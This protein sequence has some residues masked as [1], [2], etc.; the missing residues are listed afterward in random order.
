M[1]ITAKISPR[2]DYQRLDGTC[3]LRLRLFIG[4]DVKSYMIGQKILLSD[5]D[6]KGQKIRS[7]NPLAFQLN[8]YMDGQQNKAMQ[9]ILALQNTGHPVTFASF[10]N[11]WLEK[12]STDFYAWSDKYIDSIRYRIADGTYKHM[13]SEITKMK[14]FCP[15]LEMADITY[16]L[17]QNY[18][19]YMGEKLANI[20]NTIHKSIKKIRG[21]LN[22]A[23]A[24]GLIT[25]NPA[26]KVKLKMNPTNRAFLSSDQLALVENLYHN[27][28]LPTKNCKETLRHFLFGCYTGL[29]YQDITTLT[30]GDL[31]EGHI[32]LVMHKTSARVTIPFIDQACQLLP[33]MPPAPCDN[34]QVFHVLSNQKCNQHMKLISVLAGV[35]SNLSFHSARHTFATVSLNLGIPLDVVSKLLGHRDLRT[36]QIYARLMDKTKFEQMKKWDNLHK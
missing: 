5:W 23:Q 16:L 22:V 36:T 12:K 25:D 26:N 18:C 29:R 24:E 30:W 6:E 7:S 33:P 17:L 3:A 4:R 21:L 8:A 20:P 35:N 13:K 14:Q 10:E 11:Q 2:K 1:T 19:Q 27:G 32:S 9:I 28:Q 15:K 34:V 31:K